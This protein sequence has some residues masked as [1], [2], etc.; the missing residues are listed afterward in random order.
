MRSSHHRLQSR[1]G[2]TLVEVM[3]AIVLLTIVM[4][5][6]VYCGTSAMHMVNL[7]RL[8]TEARG[9]AKLRMEEVAG[10]TRDQL[11]ATGNGIL[12]PVTNTVTFD[13][14]VV[15]QTRIYWHTASGAIATAESNDYAEVHIDAMYD[16]PIT[17]RHIVNTLTRLVQ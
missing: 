5:G 1:A 16:S 10:S 2:V 11:A 6:L 13:Y 17:G 3:T 15:V 14:P 8:T 7:I 12:I 4:S 9:L